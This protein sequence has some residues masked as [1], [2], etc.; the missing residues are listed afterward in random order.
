MMPIYGN[1][2]E[3]SPTIVDSFSIQLITLQILIMKDIGFLF[4]YNNVHFVGL[5]VFRDYKTG[6][7]QY[8]W[9]E[10]DLSSVSSDIDHIIVYF[11]HPM[12]SNGG[13]HGPNLMIR[14]EFEPL[15]M[16]Y[17]VDLVF[18]WT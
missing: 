5:D 6:S 17:G 10:N 2:E 11:H 14:K 8:T 15:F 9:L 13:Y 18:S 1:H 7:E 3:D 12:Y 4:N 16:K